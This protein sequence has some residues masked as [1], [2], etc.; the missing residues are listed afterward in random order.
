MGVDTNW[1]VQNAFEYFMRER[2]PG[3]PWFVTEQLEWLE[4]GDRV[5]RFNDFVGANAEIGRD[6]ILT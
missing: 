5:A 6:V 2:R 4:E 3:V 1:Q